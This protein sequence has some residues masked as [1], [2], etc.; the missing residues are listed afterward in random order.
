MATPHM[1]DCLKVL[2]QVFLTSQLITLLKQLA[3]PFTEG[4]RQAPSDLMT[5]AGKGL[6]LQSGERLFTRAGSHGTRGNGFEIKKG[7]LILD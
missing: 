1:K 3:Q 4:G 7:R 6:F 2:G 5:E